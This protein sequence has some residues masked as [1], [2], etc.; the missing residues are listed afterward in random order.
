MYIKSQKWTRWLFVLMLVI[1]PLFKLA[2]PAAAQTDD[3]GKGVQ[4][5]IVGPITAVTDTA[6]VVNGQTITTKGA[7]IEGKLEVGKA[8]KVEAILMAN[9]TLQA[10]EIK[11]ARRGDSLDKRD[12]MEITGKLEQIGA[13]FMVVSGVRIETDGATIE[14]GVAVGSQVKLYVHLSEGKYTARAVEIVSEKKRG[15]DD[16][17]NSNDNAGNDN[18]G[19]D[20]SGNDNAGNDNSG[21]DNSGNDDHGNDNSGD[22]HGN[23][24]SDD[25][26]GNDNSGDD[27]GNDNSGHD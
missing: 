7:K 18:H 17:Q 8:V 4:V 14:K 16:N 12:E 10:R 26:H 22:D 3:K 5:T 15:S 21:N 24:N 6:I 11:V 9:A 2:T 1:F 13:G 19:N 23:D 20:N 27:H 25:D